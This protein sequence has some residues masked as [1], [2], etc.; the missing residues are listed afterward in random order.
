MRVFIGESVKIIPEIYSSHQIVD[1]TYPVEKVGKKTNKII[2]RFA[3]SIRIKNRP[4]VIDFSKL[5]A[6]QL[7]KDEYHPLNWGKTVVEKLS[8]KIGKENIGFLSVSYNISYHED[9]LP[10]LASQIVMETGLKVDSFPEEIPYYGCASAIFSIKSAVEYCKRHN[11]AAIVFSFDQCSKIGKVIYDPS[12]PY[13]KKTIKSYLLFSDGGVGLI[14]LP[15]SLID[16]Y[17]G[18][19]IEIRDIQLCYHPGKKIKT[20]HGL[21][22]L[23]SNIKEAVPPIVS[24]KVIKPVLSR[25]NVTVSDIEEWALHQGGFTILEKFKEKE[26]L[27][28]TDR[29]IERSRELF[30]NY[31]NMSS[32]SCLLVLDSFIHENK[33]KK[34]K[35]GMI[36][37]FGAGY[38]MGTVFYQWV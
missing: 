22:I 34:G 31:G 33:E 29:Q 19:L 13:F 25:N 8:E 2:H 18:K 15:E 28:L 14:I 17:E 38:Y 6:H 20:E 11:K 12:N 5:P 3:S 30:E 4:L 9:F 26:I 27:G 1:N 35:K 10:N 21:F 24:E 23:D 7:K 32:P 36:V 16:K 37:G